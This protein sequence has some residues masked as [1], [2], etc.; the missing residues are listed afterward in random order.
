M[1]EY[2][3]ADYDLV[4]RAHGKAREHKI[5]ELRAC[6]AIEGGTTFQDR[7]LDLILAKPD[8]TGADA[9]TPGLW[10]AHIDG[11]MQAVDS[12]GNGW[13][14]HVGE[15]CPY[16]KPYEGYCWVRTWAAYWADKHFHEKREQNA[17]AVFV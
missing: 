16:P 8:Y 6:G 17:L 7:W 13:T 1:V 11:I 15:C 2:T 3:R 14:V 9:P 10:D 12:D 4:R 5:R